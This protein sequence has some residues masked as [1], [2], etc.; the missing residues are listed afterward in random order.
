MRTREEALN[1]GMSFENVYEER[2]FRDPNWQ[3]VRVK[4]SKKAFL[5]IYEKDGYINL[6]VKVSPEWRDFW[7]DAYESVIAGYHQNKEHLEYDHPGR[8]RTGSG[9]P[10]NDRRKL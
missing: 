7:R 2:P 4:G 9:Y 1:Y 5:W 10:E 6:N 8:K 3:L